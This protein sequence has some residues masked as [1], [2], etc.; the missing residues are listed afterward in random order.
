VTE[1]RVLT[2]RDTDSVVRKK[3]A[4]CLLKLFRTNPDNITHPDWAPQMV[5]AST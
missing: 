2:A 1:Q 5:R 4:L 3:A